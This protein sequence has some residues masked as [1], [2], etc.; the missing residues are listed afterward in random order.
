MG[1]NGVG[2]SGAGRLRGKWRR[3]EKR[4][5]A[6]LGRTANPTKLAHCSWLTT[7]MPSCVA[8]GVRWCTRPFL[9]ARALAL[10]TSARGQTGVPWFM[11][12]GEAGGVTWLM[13]VEGDKKARGQLVKNCAYPKTFFLFR[14]KRS[15][16]VTQ[17]WII[18]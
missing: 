5:G 16:N 12:R 2:G 15:L 4:G 14:V 18:F 13:G 6:G 1:V 9:I 8:I 3:G 10:S 17:D 11:N 7:A